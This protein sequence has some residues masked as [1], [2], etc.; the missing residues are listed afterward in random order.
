MHADMADERIRV[1]LIDDDVAARTAVARHLKAQASTYVLWQTGSPGEATQWIGESDFDVVLIGYRP[2]EQGKLR[3]LK[4]LGETP[5]ILLTDSGGEETAAR[6]VWRGIHDCLIR[7]AAGNYLFL[8]ATKIGKVV[9]RR[10]AEDATRCK[11]EFLANM[12]HEIRTPL[13]AIIGFAETL[14][15]E[16]DFAH[17]PPQRVEAVHAIIRNGRHLLQIIADILDLSKVEA[18]MLNVERINCSPV[19]LVSEVQQLLRVRAESKGLALEVQYAGPIP[20][21][22]QTDPTRLTQILLNLLGNALKFTKTG[23]VRTVVQM[24]SPESPQTMMQIEVIDTGIGIRPEQVARV[25]EPFSQADISTTRRFGGTGLGLAICRRLAE[26]L[27]GQIDV[28]SHPGQGSTFRVT[29]S[30]GSLDGVQM[31]DHPQ[32]RAP[33]CVEPMARSALDLPVIPP[34]CRILL[35]EDAPD[36]QRLL[37]LLLAKAGAEVSVADEGQTAVQCALAQWQ[38]GLP[39]DLILM[40]MQMPILDGYRATRK[41]R[42]EG[43]PGPIVALTANAMS[44]QRERCL[45]AGCDGYAAKPIQRDTLLDTVA[46]YARRHVGRLTPDAPDGP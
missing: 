3:L 45:A 35:V 15:V 26:K 11:S 12:S 39:F 13:T 17:A 34:G 6:A 24:V 29:I 27:G 31:I 1:L 41:L 4:Q 5:A 43:Y 2:H 8:L 18:G 20:E 32:H 21:T 7:D 25:F 33:P 40:D 16:D 19:E 22:I 23:S 37:S 38:A 42:S 9:A 14:L 46:Q 44:G 30:T 28:E 10:R 36:T